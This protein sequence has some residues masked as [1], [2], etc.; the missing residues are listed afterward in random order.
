[1]ANRKWGL[2][3]KQ[4]LMRLLAATLLISHQRRNLRTPAQHTLHSSKRER[5]ATRAI[6]RLLLILDQM[7]VH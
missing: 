6:Q 3:Q 4:G 5:W 7:Q 1:M 2:M